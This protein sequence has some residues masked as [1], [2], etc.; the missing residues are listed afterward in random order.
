MDGTC[1]STCKA[2]DARRGYISAIANTASMPV[3]AR[4]IGMCHYRDESGSCDWRR[5]SCDRFSVSIQGVSSATV[6]SP[7]DIG[8]SIG[9]GI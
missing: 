5:L 9:V 7:N 4:S 1:T 6:S 8:A 2:P 3:S